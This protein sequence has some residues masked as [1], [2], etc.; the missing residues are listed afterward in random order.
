MNQSLEDLSLLIVDDIPWNIQVLAEGLRTLCRIRVATGGPKAL[1]IATSDDPPDLILLDVMMPEMDGYEV[2]RRLKDNPRTAGIPVIFVTARGEVEDEARGLE[3]G[4]V[5]YITK[6]FHLPVVRAR[7]RTHLGLKL[8][9]DQL[10]RLSAVDGLTGI[11]NRR[12]FDE[13]LDREWRRD[14]RLGSSLAV[15]MLDVDQFKTYNDHL[16]HGRGDECLVRVAQALAAEIHR[17]SDG[18]FR[19]GGEEFVALLGNTDPVGAALLAD[20]FRQAVEHLEIPHPASSVGP[21][22]TV[23]GGWKTTVP[24]PDKSSTLLVEAADRGLFRAKREGRNRV[25][26]GIWQGA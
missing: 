22:V 7:V 20:R 6:P 9:T 18:V 24:D 10:E 2:C 8:K 21:W 26:E 25:C 3:L 11:A 19:Y 17:P 1:D 12:R 16:G 4:A 14:L 13:T 15:V 5:D 23:S